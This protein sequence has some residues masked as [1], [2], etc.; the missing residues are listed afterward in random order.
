MTVAMERGGNASAQ[1]PRF[2]EACKKWCEVPYQ[3]IVTLAIQR[4][5]WSV[6]RLAEMMLQITIA[7]AIVVATFDG[8]NFATLD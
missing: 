4:S 2:W 7:V 5:L 3:C 8:R 1:V 6:S